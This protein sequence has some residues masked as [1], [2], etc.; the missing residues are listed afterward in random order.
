MFLF[1]L[2]CF[3]VCFIVLLF[4]FSQIDW[5]SHSFILVWVSCFMVASRQG[6]ATFLSHQ[7]CYTNSE[8]FLFLSL[9]FLLLTKNK[10]SV[11]ANGPTKR[12]K[13]EVLQPKTKIT[14]VLGTQWGDEGKGKLVDILATTADLV[15]RC[16]VKINSK[17]LDLIINS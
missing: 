16:Q 9:I 13:V 17:N 2:F 11:I 10:M 15:C 3:F 6:A 4:Y 7:S 5:L 12:R 8:S 1:V 14:V